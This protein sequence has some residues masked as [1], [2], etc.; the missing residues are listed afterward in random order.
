MIEKIKET[1]GISALLQNI[2]LKFSV[3]NSFQ[4][5]LFLYL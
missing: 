3:N 2:F 5:L 4:Y 1:A